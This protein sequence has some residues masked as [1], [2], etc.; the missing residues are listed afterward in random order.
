MNSLL[1]AAAWSSGVR[2]I[3]EI[4]RTSIA[5]PSAD[6][7]YAGLLMLVLLTLRGAK[8][9]KAPSREPSDLQE[10]QDIPTEL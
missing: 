10:D 4:S 1:A 9:E 5:D 2:L 6:L 7:T 3:A 8:G